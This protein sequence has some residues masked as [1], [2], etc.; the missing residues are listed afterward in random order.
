MSQS[1]D[2]RRN[3]PDRSFVCLM[4]AQVRSL[5]AGVGEDAT[6][7]DPQIA[8]KPGVRLARSLNNSSC[9]PCRAGWRWGMVPGDGSHDGARPRGAW[10]VGGAR[11]AGSADPAQGARRS[12]PASGYRSDLVNYELGRPPSPGALAEPM[13]RPSPT[14]T[15][16][17]PSPGALAEP[18]GPT[19]PAAT[20][21]RTRRDA[22]GAGGG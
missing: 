22:R 1:E 4:S 13:R 17:S 10:G 11:P 5:V 15:G 7:S 16:T 2:Q 21:R 19:K 20:T 6:I 9:G 12:R 3:H 8:T 18:M 14:L